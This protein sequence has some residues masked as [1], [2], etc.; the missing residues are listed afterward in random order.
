MEKSDGLR[1]CRAAETSGDG[2]E[3]A[4]RDERRWEER[5]E[6]RRGKGEEK[7]GGREGKRRGE[8]EERGGV[9][10]YGKDE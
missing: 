5:D 3:R 2:P 6:R 8:R 7:S 1:E 9:K 10:W 4:E